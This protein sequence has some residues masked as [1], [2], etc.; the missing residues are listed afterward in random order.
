MS[1]KVITI[2]GIGDVRILK[3]KGQKTV[4]IAVSGSIVSVTQPSWLPFS[5]GEDYARSKADWAKQNLKPASVF[6]NG[7]ELAPGLILR[8]L[9]SSNKLKSISSSTSLIVYIPVAI[10]LTSVKA[11]DYI[12]KSIT[13][14]LRSRAENYLP[15]RV[16]TLADMFGFDFKSVG[17]RVLKRRWGSC[18]SKKELVFN[19]NLIRLDPLHVDYVILHELTHTLHMNHGPQFWSHLESVYPGAKKIAKVV[20]RY[21]M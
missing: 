20:R 19:I 5:V 21:Q 2:D 11:Q 14:Y 8:I 12:S 3:R 9:Q 15:G 13:E 17:V 6:V 10:E 18:N 4:R 16:K 7:Q 1:V